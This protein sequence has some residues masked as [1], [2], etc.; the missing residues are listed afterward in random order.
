MQALQDT[1]S[2]FRYVVRFVALAPDMTGSD[3][4]QPFRVYN[5]PAHVQRP[6]DEEDV[7]WQGQLIPQPAGETVLRGMLAGGWR[8]YPLS[9]REVAALLALVVILSGLLQLGLGI[10]STFGGLGL[11]LAA[12]FIAWRYA[13][14]HRQR[15]DLVRAIQRVCEG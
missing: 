4:A 12:G 5:L 7:C 13:G 8:F 3:A 10:S 1:P 6:P 9:W 15:A 2:E 11:L 14:Y